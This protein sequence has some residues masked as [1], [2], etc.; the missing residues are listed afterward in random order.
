MK[1]PSLLMLIRHDVSVYNA[2]KAKK[3]K[4][5]LYQEFL[6]AWKA[7]PESDKTRRFAREAH[8]IFKLDFGDHDT[9]LAEA[10]G[11]QAET[12]GKMLKKEFG[13]PDVIHV[14]PYLRAR[15]TLEFM[16]KG[17]PELV[18]AKT[19]EEERI[20][21]QEHGLALLYNDWRVFEAL[22]PEQRLLYNL[23]GS[24]W[25]RYP[26]GENIPDVRGRNRDWLSTLIREFSGKRVM[27]ITHHLNILVTRANLERFGEEEFV[28]LDKEEKPINCG[29]TVYR[30][31]PL[32]GKDGKLVLN[33][34]N[35][36]YY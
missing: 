32:R 27:A 28:R 14:S 34:Y 12:T 33:F 17:W 25:Y 36:K 5:P 6:R 29:V 2:L 11:R 10:E 22:H 7:D 30:E 16:I 3:N 15:L 26:Q 35:K 31:K 18:E 4:N 23:E 8:K 1:W 13:P 21:E 19:Y 24:Y 20:R 9:P